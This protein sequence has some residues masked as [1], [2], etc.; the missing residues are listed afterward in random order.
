MGGGDE[1]VLDDVVGL[2]CRALH[3]L[4]ATALRTVEVGLGPLRVAGAGDRDDDVFLGDQIFHR[5]VAVVGHQAGTPLVP[6]LV[7]DLAHLVADD[8]TLPAR[9]GQDVV[10]VLD[11]GGYLVVL[12]DDPLAFQGGQPTKLQVEDGDGLDLVDLQQR[13]QST[14]GG[15][16]GR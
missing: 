15:V 2:Q 8:L 4:A 10:V 6:E 11:L 3:A 5:H 16:C 7:D 14:A 12:V 1:E 9:P 13:H